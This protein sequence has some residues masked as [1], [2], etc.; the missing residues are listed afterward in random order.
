MDLNTKIIIVSI[1]LLFAILSASWLNF[2]A[3]KR[4]IEK[5]RKRIEAKIDYYENEKSES[6][7]Y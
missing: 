1:I 2:R 4:I 6:R 7:F 3:K 5:M